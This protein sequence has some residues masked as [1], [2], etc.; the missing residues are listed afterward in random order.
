MDPV[1]PSIPDLNADPPR[2]RCRCKGILLHPTEHR[3]CR[4]RRRH[5][6][7]GGIAGDTIM[8]HWC[9]FLFGEVDKSYMNEQEVDM[10]GGG[11]REQIATEDTYYDKAG[12]GGAR[13]DMEHHLP[14]GRR[15][16][17]RR[18]DSSGVSAHYFLA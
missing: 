10:L 17:R 7:E 3:Q 9:R 5:P 16:R 18:V 12:N 11:A 4:S 2:C 6:T 13:E 1:P 15:L 14:G 8:E